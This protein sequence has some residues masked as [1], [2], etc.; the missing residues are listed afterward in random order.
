MKINEREQLI[1]LDILESLA[2][3]QRA[4]ARIIESVADSVESSPQLAGQIAD[5]LTSIVGYQR[6]LA[7]K[8]IGLPIRLK[9]KGIPRQPWLNASTGVHQGK[10]KS[11]SSSK[12]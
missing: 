2:R 9:Q 8:I 4:L 5:N 10:R 12:E 3:S 1:K 11:P 6:I 7:K